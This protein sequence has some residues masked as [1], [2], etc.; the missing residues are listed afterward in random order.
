MHNLL[1]EKY[2]GFIIPPRPDK[3]YIKNMNDKF[4]EERRSQ[5]E[6]YLNIIIKHPIMA[7]STAFKVFTQTPNEKFDRE[8]VKAEETHETLEFKSLEDTY[9]KVVSIVQNKLQ[10]MLS[11][12]IIPFSKEMSNIEDKILKLEAPIHTLSVSFA[13]WTQKQI[14]S[15]RIL[16]TFILPD[17]SKFNDMVH[18][19]KRISNNH[20]NDL[21]KLS[22]EFH[23]EFLRLEGLKQAITSY[24]NTIDEYAQQET[25]ISRKLIKHKSSSN[26]DTAARYLSEIQKTQDNL[27]RISKT[28]T[29]IEETLVKE[30]ESLDLSRKQHLLE[31]IGEIAFKQ[32]NYYESESLFWNDALFS[33]GHNKEDF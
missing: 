21:N 8:K 19:Y 5:M 27:D 9:D 10:I 24:K 32:K 22:L 17:V 13:N 20:L 12:K 28:I 6:K 25:L 30:N 26:E 11:Q 4:L 14:E 23:E 15:T 16:D 2:K 29:Q 18:R 7:N 1:V 31:T 33:I 3:A